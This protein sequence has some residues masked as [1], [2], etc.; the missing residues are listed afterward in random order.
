MST[1]RPRSATSSKWDRNQERA[2]VDQGGWAEVIGLM[3]EPALVQL[4]ILG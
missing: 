3:E 4:R 2:F 1:Q